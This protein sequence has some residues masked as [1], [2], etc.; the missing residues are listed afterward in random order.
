[1]KTSTVLGWAVAMLVLAGLSASPGW[2]R[3]QYMG[4]V[5]AVFVA[6]MNNTGGSS[7]SATQSTAPVKTH[8]EMKSTKTAKST[9]ATT[10]S[11]YEHKKGFHPIRATG[12]AIGRTAEFAGDVAGGTVKFVGNTAGRAVKSVGRGVH[13]VFGSKKA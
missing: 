2:G 13:A 4:N 10:S 5:P 11:T 8:K 9:K 6:S 7:N 12:K 3:D 1:M